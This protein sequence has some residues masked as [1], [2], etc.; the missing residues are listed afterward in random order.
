MTELD[1]YAFNAGRLAALME[2]AIRDGEQIIKS[3]ASDRVEENGTCDCG[4]IAVRDG[5]C[6]ACEAVFSPQKGT[7]VRTD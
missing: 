1:R 7:W 3:Y 5:K 4:E 2:L 6:E